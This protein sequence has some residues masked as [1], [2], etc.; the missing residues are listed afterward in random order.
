MVYDQAL[1]AVGVPGWAASSV[2]AVEA[3]TMPP[4]MPTDDCET[5]RHA[6]SMSPQDREVFSAWRDGGFALGDEADYVTPEVEPE[7]DH[8]APDL[9][10]SASEPYLPSMASPDDYHCIPLDH[11]FD[12]EVWVR[13]FDVFPDQKN[14]VH[15]VILYRLSP[16][17]A[18]IADELDAAEDGPGYTCFG[19]PGTWSADTLA[20]WA[21]G[22]R[23]EFYDE[24][25]ARRIE[26]DSKLVIQ[27]H[28]N[29]LG[30]TDETPLRPDK[31]EVHLWTLPPGER[32]I[33]QV[34]SIPVANQ[35]ISLPAGDPRVVEDYRF[36]LDF[37]GDVPFTLQTIGVMPHMHQLGTRIRADVYDENGDESCIIDIRSWDFNWQQTYFFEETLE[38][39]SKEVVNLRC[40]YDNSVENQPVVNGEQRQP[41][42]VTWG[43]G[44]YDE[45]CL[46]Y[47]LALVPPGLL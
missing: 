13:G 47:F 29:L 33:S 25:I 43:D 41:A 12:E 22:Q 28:Y 21:P 14:L 40:V 17:D 46:M 20:A 6:R 24:G 27:V 36:D 26:P 5:L 19:S 7:P 11:D 37:L 1:W 35:R 9:V 31:S 10:L 15:H 38:T 44:S 18:H 2:A 3:E 30:A 23:P 42:D 16:E 45:M 4:W 32:P 8:G 34:V 39:T